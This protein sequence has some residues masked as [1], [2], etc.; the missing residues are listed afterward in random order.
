MLSK[1]SQADIL[2]SDVDSFTAT[3]LSQM[4][5]SSGAADCLSP[6]TKSQHAEISS[7]S[8][9]RTLSQ[10]HLA[11]G[12]L[13]FQTLAFEGIAERRA[14][15]MTGRSRTDLRFHL[16]AWIMDSAVRFSL[17]AQ[18]APLISFNLTVRNT[19]AYS[20]EKSVFRPARVG[21]VDH[22][23][24]LFSNGDATPNDIEAGNGLTALKACLTRY[25]L[26]NTIPL[27]TRFSTQFDTSAWTLS[28]SSFTRER[29][30]IWKT[31][32]VCKSVSTHA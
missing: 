27:F 21:N 32:L 17:T 11:T 30:Q 15:V 18:K 3:N 19:V 14:I 1:L 16:P 28:I 20:N 23:K 7:I 26:N 4:C 12:I 2:V 31:T 13:Q 5:A 9:F 29:I 10:S 8:T 22:L 24:R 6:P 25:Q